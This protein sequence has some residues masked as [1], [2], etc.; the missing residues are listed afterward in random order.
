MRFVRECKNKKRTHQHKRALIDRYTKEI[1]D[2][3]IHIT[4]TTDMNSEKWYIVERG[5]ELRLLMRNLT[6]CDSIAGT[7]AGHILTCCSVFWV[8]YAFFDAGP[9]VWNFSVHRHFST[10]GTTLER[11][12][13][14]KSI[15]QIIST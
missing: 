1:C 11:S 2:R 12:R 5:R 9:M 3:Y 15:N 13:Q 8:Y 7:I 14:D 6:E 4:H 10:L